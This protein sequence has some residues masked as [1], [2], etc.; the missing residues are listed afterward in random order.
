MQCQ[1]PQDSDLR[2]EDALLDAQA[3][4]FFEIEYKHAQPSGDVFSRLLAQIESD[5]ELASDIHPH[6]PILSHQAVKA[7]YEALSR[8][9]IGRLVPGSIALML[10]VVLLG[11]D[12]SQ[13]LR[14]EGEML[15]QGE[16]NSSS[17]ALFDQSPGNT[18]ETIRLHN[19]ELK[20]GERFN[21][22]LDY[23][24][25]DAGTLDPVELGE[26]RRNTFRVQAEPQKLDDYER[27]K[28]GPE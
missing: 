22:P 15:S 24:P 9:I 27:T 23:D 13:I 20:T 4:H 5:R 10:V 28:F 3:R 26:G 8:P 18:S 1:S 12:I 25:Q 7:L 2:Y 17:P 19:L 6:R 14:G 11:S 16:Y 21:A